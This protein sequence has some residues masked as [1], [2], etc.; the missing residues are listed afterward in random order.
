MFTCSQHFSARKE[1][2]HDLRT[3]SL[4]VNNA[5]VYIRSYSQEKYNK[6]IMQLLEKF[7]DPVAVLLSVDVE[8]DIGISGE[9]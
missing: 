1:K 2:R 3:D 8:R 5:A 6:K 7:P 9:D 4:F